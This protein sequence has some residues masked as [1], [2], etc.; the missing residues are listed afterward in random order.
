M[1]LSL[2]QGNHNINILA[3]PY[4]MYTVY[5]HVCYKCYVKKILDYMVLIWQVTPW[6]NNL[7]SPLFLHQTRLGLISW[8]LSYLSTS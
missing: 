4:I 5:A 7:Q 8:L 3:T 6:I 1:R 2:F